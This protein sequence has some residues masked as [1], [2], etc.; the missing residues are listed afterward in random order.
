MR[1][2]RERL[3]PCGSFSLGGGDDIA[4]LQQGIGQFAGDIRT[5]ADFAGDIAFSEQLLKGIHHR[6]ARDAQ[7]A[8]EGAG[9]G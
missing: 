4:N 5:G 3:R 7:L 9:S 1:P 2:R 6:I 8:G